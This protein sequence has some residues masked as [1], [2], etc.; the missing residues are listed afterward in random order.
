MLNLFKKD[1]SI[2]FITT[3]AT[4]FFLEELITQAEQRLILISPFIKLHKKLIQLLEAKRNEGVTII[5]VCREQA[6]NSHLSKIASHLVINPNLHAK[7]YFTEKAS[8]ITS[9][10]LYEFSQVNNDEMGILIRNKG[11]GK[12]LHADVASEVT[13]LVGDLSNSPTPK[14]LPNYPLKIGQ[15]YQ[16]EQL[17]KL[18]NFDFK[19]RSGIKQAADGSIVLFSYSS[20]SYENK[21][22]AG[23]IYYQ[24]QNTGQG[25]QKLIYGNKA[26]YDAYTDK[27]L[28]I[29]LFSNNIFKGLAEVAE[30]PAQENGKW[31]FPLRLTNS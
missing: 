18:F 1:T 6:V 27:S 24:G 8:L 25:K 30:K 26:L 22:K 14:Q 23:V 4:N 13:R 17:D 28:Q 7:C 12:S 2:K 9:L 5:I 10:N 11:Y 29:Y 16:L 19:G 21:V 20:S 3:Q 15:K 31:I